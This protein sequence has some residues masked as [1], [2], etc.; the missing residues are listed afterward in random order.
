MKI[1][2]ISGLNRWHSLYKDTSCLSGVPKGSVGGPLL[3]LMYINDLP[4]ALG[5]SAFLFMDPAIKI[6]L[7]F[8]NKTPTSAHDLL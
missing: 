4:C 5:D 7:A 1:S 3:F 6:K 2:V 8:T